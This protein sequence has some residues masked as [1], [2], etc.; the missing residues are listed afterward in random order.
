MNNWKYNTDSSIWEYTNLAFTKRVDTGST[1]AAALPTSVIVNVSGAVMINREH[2]YISVE[3]DGHVFWS[4]SK[5][6]EKSCQGKWS[7]YELSLYTPSLQDQSE[8]KCFAAID[9]TLPYI[10]NADQLELSVRGTP[11]HKNAYWGFGEIMLSYKE[12]ATATTKTAIRGNL[13]TMGIPEFQ[14]YNE[15]SNYCSKKGLSLCNADSICNGNLPHYGL[16]YGKELYYAV[17]NVSETWIY[18]GNKGTPCKQ[19][20]NITETAPFIRTASCCKTLANPTPCEEICN[21][22]RECV[23]GYFDGNADECHLTSIRSR[24]LKDCPSGETCNAFVPDRSVCSTAAY[25]AIPQ[26]G[27]WKSKTYIHSA[28]VTVDL[29]APYRS[30]ISNYI[31]VKPTDLIEFRTQ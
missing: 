3:V 21:G 17:N 20:G 9:V 1:I 19:V 14:T 7:S 28:T 8:V 5:S 13:D 2:S 31:G 10:H 12:S 4:S 27:K 22:N 25:V 11:P 26:K 6:S 18:V 16:V 24:S 23:A 29:G 15:A 30:I